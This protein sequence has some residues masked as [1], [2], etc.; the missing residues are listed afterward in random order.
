[1]AKTFDNI[2]EASATNY[3]FLFAQRT[4]ALK[5][6]PPTPPPL[7]ALGLPCE[8]M[9]R[10]WVRM[11]PEKAAAHEYLSIYLKSIGATRTVADTKAAGEKAAEPEPE[12]E[13][14]SEPEPKPEPEP[15]PEPE[16]APE[17]APE[18][19]PEPEGEAAEGEVAEGEAAEGE[20]APEENAAEQEN[21]AA[22]DELLKAAATDDQSRSST[23]GSWDFTTSSWSFTSPLSSE[24]APTQD[25]EKLPIEGAAVLEERAA[26]EEA[27]EAAGVVAAAGGIN[28]TAEKATRGGGLKEK[29]FAEK[30]APLAKEITEYILGHQDDAAQEDRWRTTMKRETMKRFRELREASDAQGQAI[31]EVHQLIKKIANAN[32][33][34]IA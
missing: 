32:Q 22:E 21:E 31:N 1:M 2:S 16:P 25:E 23:A 13:P 26:A 4:L 8:A 15:E 12:S 29:P 30:I 24:K 6:E 10:L 17:P 33:P 28:A 11:Y 34:Y 9:C 3:L 7:N 14:E 19:E 27:A 18:P 20:A 5:N